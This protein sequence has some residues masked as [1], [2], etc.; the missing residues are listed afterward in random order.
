MGNG[1]WEVICFT[2]FLLASFV[3]FEDEK[4]EM[5]KLN[6]VFQIKISFVINEVSG[7]SNWIKYFDGLVLQTQLCPFILAVDYR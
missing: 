3:A 7:K 1:S 5:K 6:T 2:S 4:V